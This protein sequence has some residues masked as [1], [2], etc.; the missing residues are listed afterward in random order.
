MVLAVQ[1]TPMQ[2][3]QADISSEKSK[4]PV[5]N[6]LPLY[7]GEAGEFLVTLSNPT[8]SS[9][10]WKLEIEGDFP[11]DWCNR[12]QTSF[13]EILPRGKREFP[14]YL[15]VPDNFF[16]DS[17]TI[18]KNQPRLQID[19]Q[20]QISIYTTQTGNEP[21]LIKYQVLNLLVRP[22]ISYLDF[23]PNIYQE[24]DFVGRLVG[25]F[26]QAFDPVVQ[27]IDT[28]WAYLDPL[29]APTALQNFLAHWVAWDI[30]S[31]WDIDKQRQLIRNAITIY[32]W[33]G[34]RYGLRLYLHLYTGLPLDEDS[35]EVDK[36]I[37]IQEVF[38]NGFVLGKTFIG[39]DSMIGGG[40]PYHFIVRLRAT[41]SLHIDE[42]LVRKIIEQQKPAFSTYELSIINP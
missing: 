5:S 22:N 16:E 29:T 32:R 8:D 40:R 15:I 23:L 7:P 39:Q 24:V 21:Q 10:E 41:E 38:N 34:T 1:I 31:R 37:S 30:D 25:I 9:L 19:Y 27:T 17:H 42:S 36:H 26:E 18:N 6:N 2:P 14:I 12:N 4:E 35:P 33:H 11:S 20:M 13:E 28:L 3:L